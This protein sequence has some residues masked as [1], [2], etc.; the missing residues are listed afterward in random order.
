[1]HPIPYGAGCAIRAWCGTVKVLWGSIPHTELL[2]N[3]QKNTTMA[4][5][6]DVCASLPTE[7]VEHEEKK[8]RNEAIRLSER[9]AWKEQRKAEH[10]RY[11]AYRQ[12]EERR[13]IRRGEHG[14]SLE[15][16]RKAVRRETMPEPVRETRKDMFF[17]GQGVRQQKK[18]KNSASSEEMGTVGRRIVVKRFA[19]S[20]VTCVCKSRIF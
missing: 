16:S 12:R 6:S 19:G 7:W 5:F 11:R 9:L 15:S 1:M 8:E 20:R 18:V 10:D 17:Y 13:A 3:F 2:Y 4:K 14:V